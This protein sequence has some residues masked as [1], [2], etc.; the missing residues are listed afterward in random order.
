MGKGKAASRVLS[1]DGLFDFVVLYVKN[2]NVITQDIHAYYTNVII[3][4]LIYISVDDDFLSSL[5]S[6]GF[7]A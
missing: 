5:D 1:A 2:Q 3:A 6:L 4:N 7:M